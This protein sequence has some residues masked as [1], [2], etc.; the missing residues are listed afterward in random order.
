M[1]QINRSFKHKWWCIHFGQEISDPVAAKRLHLFLKRY[2]NHRVIGRH[3]IFLDM[4]ESRGRHAFLLF[5]KKVTEVAEHLNLNP[6]SWQWGM[7]KTLAESWVHTRWR[8]LAVDQLPIDALQDYANP[9]E[10]ERVSV[11]QVRRLK[12]LKAQGSASLQDLIELSDDELE[13]QAGSTIAEIIRE[14][15]ERDDER[16]DVCLERMTSESFMQSS[17]SF[18]LED[19]IPEEYLQ[20]G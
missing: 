7:G 12:S 20:V 10:F 15:F 18:Q 14:H 6:E 13:S 19:W 16:R 11:G 8:T 1:I 9:L 5:Q 2:T 17:G 3:K 4:S